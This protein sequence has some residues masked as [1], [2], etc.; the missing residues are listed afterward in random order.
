MLESNFPVDKGMYS[1]H[2]LWNCFK[3]LSSSLSP[4]LKDYLFRKTASQVYRLQ[5]TRTGEKWQMHACGARRQ[6]LLLATRPRSVSVPSGS[7]TLCARLP[8]G[9]GGHTE[10]SYDF[11]GRE[12]SEYDGV[13]NRRTRKITSSG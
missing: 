8:C 2:L 10:V 7:V 3:K 4:E 6:P 11:F 1:Y 12:S 5:A 13:T 9:P